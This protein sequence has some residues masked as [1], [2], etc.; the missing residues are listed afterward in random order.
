MSAT[1]PSPGYHDWNWLPTASNPS[2]LAPNLE[3]LT[4]QHVPFTWSAPIF[5]NNL[6]KLVL[7]SIS[8]TLP[9]LNQIFYILKETAETLESVSLHF[10]TVLN[11]VIPLQ[12]VTLPRLKSLSIGGH[13][14]LSTLVDN[15][16]LPAVE[17]LNLDIEARDSIEDTLHSLTANTPGLATGLKHLSVAYGYGWSDSL[18][19]MHSSF[20]HGSVTNWQFLTDFIGLE[21]LRIGGCPVEVLLNALS[22]PDEEVGTG[23]IGIGGVNGWVCPQL[24]TLGLKNCAG[25]SEAWTKTVQDTWGKLVQAIENRTTGTMVGGVKPVPIKTLELLDSQGLGVDVLSWLNKRCAVTWTEIDRP[26]RYYVVCP[27]S[28]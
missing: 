7:R 26:Q 22:H 15:L 13:Y 11:P 20:Y 23:A 5:Q 24:H 6:R 9:P 4:L 10:H 12:Q 3:S 1:E 14:L 2:Q 27:Y 19:H 18:D 8:S 16:V 28:S 25:H 21:S 17:Q